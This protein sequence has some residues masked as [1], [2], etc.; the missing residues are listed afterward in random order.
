MRPK[1][2]LV[3]LPLTFYLKKEGEQW[4]ALS[5]ELTVASCGETLD[6]GPEGLKDAIETYV[7]Y[8]LS[9]GRVHEIARPMDRK[10]VGDFL[11][12]PPG[13][14]VVEEHSLSVASEGGGCKFTTPLC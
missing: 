6:E 1:S 4:A 7:L 11:A 5:P 10:D 8:M 9:Q 14:C 3:A 2:D 12:D 13:E